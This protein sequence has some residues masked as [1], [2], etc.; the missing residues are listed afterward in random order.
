MVKPPPLPSVPSPLPPTP[1]PLPGNQRTVEASELRTPIEG[2][3][4]RTAVKRYAIKFI[5]I[6]SITFFIMLVV[7]FLLDDRKDTPWWY[8]VLIPPGVAIPIAGIGAFLNGIVPKDP[9]D[10][11]PNGAAAP[12]QAE[13]SATD[14]Y[15]KLDEAVKL[16][17][18]RWIFFSLMLGIGSGLC[19]AILSGWL[20]A[21]WENRELVP[22][23]GRLLLGIG[24]IGSAVFAAT[25]GL[26]GVLCSRLRKLPFLAVTVSSLLMFAVS[27]GAIVGGSYATVSI[28]QSAKES[29][30]QARQRSNQI[31]G[32]PWFEGAKDLKDKKQ[33]S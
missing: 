2:L 20:S 5:V 9:P 10:A 29:A 18:G 19:I 12:V 26:V 27:V 11:S 1:P 31:K 25:C 22:K 16:P 30:D 32:R 8:Y 17:G 6:F 33:S 28:V 24:V 21:I 14:S 23:W 7:W 4:R 3:I 13:S 15:G